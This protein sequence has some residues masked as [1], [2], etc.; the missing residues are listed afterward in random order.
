M[1]RLAIAV[2]VL[3]A[4]SA[5]KQEKHEAAPAKP[6]DAGPPPPPKVELAPAREM[7]K[8]A[9]PVVE[10]PADNPT[11]AEKAEL[12]WMLFFDKRLSKDGSKACVDC[13]H[14]DKA[15]TSGQATDAKVGG[16]MNKRNSP[17]ML[18]LGYAKSWYWDGRAATLEAVSAAAWKGQLGAVPEETA[19]ALAKNPTYKALFERAFKSGPTADNV[20]Q[21]LAVFFRTLGTTEAAFDKFVAGD[22]KAIPADAAKGFE[23]FKKKGCVNCHVPPLFSDFDFHRVT[24]MPA[25]DADQGRKDGT[26]ADEDAGKWKAPSLRNVALT[27][28]Y[29]HDGSAKTLD[30]VFDVMSG[31]KLPKKVKGLD[32]KFK[33]SKLAPKE[34]AQLK[35]FLE[36]LSSPPTWPAAPEKLP[37]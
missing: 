23:L 21:A 20:P 7:P 4:V 3:A 1:N 31:A 13:H 33:P 25:A 26:K 29:L 32:P 24:A 10:A 14:I 12:G 36:T 9:L 16:A 18:N 17:S 8:L 5:C 27:G 11:T 19:A 2:A 22:K 37:E 28:P 35:A 15:Y 6:V 30:E 34:R